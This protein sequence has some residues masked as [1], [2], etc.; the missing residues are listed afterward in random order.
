MPL[1]PHL[2]KA[3]KGPTD[4]AAIFM[5]PRSEL[6]RIIALGIGQALTLVAFIVLLKL[7]IDNVVAAPG[8]LATTLP[9]IGALA[10]AT[11]LNAMLRAAEFSYAERM[12]FEMVRR[13]RMVMYEHLAGMS[14]RQLQHR[15]RGALLLRFTGDLTMFRTWISR[16]VAR[17]MVAVI[18][19]A[20]ATFVLAW[21]SLWM[22]LAAVGVLFGGAALSLTMGRRLRRLTRWV[23]RKRSLLTSN[24][25]EQLS[26]LSTVQAFGRWSGEMARMGRQNDSL[27]RTLTREARV[28][29]ALR[30]IAAGSGRL[31]MVGVLAVG[32]VEVAATQVTVG[33]LV[34]A[35][36]VIPQLSATVRTLGLAHDYWQRA[37][38][39]K[40]KITDFLESQTRPLD[41]EDAPPLRVRRGRIDI[42]AATVRGA[43]EGIDTVV[44]PGELIAITGPTGAGK[45]TLLSSIARLVELDAGEI[46]IDG[47]DVAK[48]RLGSIYR[49]IGIVSPDLPLLRGTIRRNLTYR[50]RHASA[51]EIQRIV[52]TWRLDEL[53]ADQ[54]LG[55]D[56]WL[57]EGG[58]N[59]SAGQRHRLSLAR[60]VLGN[61]TILLLDEPATALDA[62]SRELV[63]RVISRY[64]GTV[65]LVTH[66][67]RE[68]AIADRVWVLNDGEL[69]GDYSAE[70][71]RRRSTVTA[72]VETASAAHG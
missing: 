25:D 49:S 66:D 70:E 51:E 41:A 39:S 60:A 58:R 15:S 18:V 20:G 62:E 7:V 50:D 5:P 26:A 28:R 48:H 11:L 14:A 32:A 68:I 16:G 46:L 19:I 31:A 29:G 34:A 21:F 24:V 30:G 37:Q 52:M 1:N 4:Q 38:I 43:I 69:V 12:G 40:G 6:A 33:S 36:M 17:G 59:L 9:L 65:V 42:R 23:R 63:R 10:V 54:T 47:Q 8:D 2:V 27:T 44:E 67:E 45:S 57:V 72:P 71:Y 55:L 56:T 53:F 13:L 3:M 61:P 64:E 35:L 22:A